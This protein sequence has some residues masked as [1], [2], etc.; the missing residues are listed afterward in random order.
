VAS[1]TTLVRL[2]DAK[3]YLQ[4]HLEAASSGLAPLTHYIRVG[5]A[6]GYDPHPM[7][8]TSWYLERYPDIAKAGMNPLVHYAQHGGFEGRDP[9]P[10][11]DTKWYLAQYPD[12]STT[13][14]NP[15][16]HYLEHGLAEGR[17]PGP[18]VLTP[19]DWE[20]DPSAAAAARA[21]YEREIG[22]R[23]PR[24]P[25]INIGRWPSPALLRWAT[26]CYR[27]SGFYLTSLLC[28]LGL[29]V[30]PPQLEYHLALLIKSYVRQG[31][32]DDA[33]RWFLHR[34]G[35]RPSGGP[36][37]L[38]AMPTISQGR[39]TYESIA[40][41]T[42]LM[43][44]RIAAQSA[45]LQSW[46]AAGMSVVSVNS[47][48][49]AIELRQYFPDVSYKTIEPTLEDMRGRPFVPIRALIETAK[50]ASADI[51]GIVN[52]DIE[53]RGGRDF[54]DTVRREVSGALVFGNRIDLTEAAATTGTAFRN[55]YDFFFWDRENSD[56][57]KDNPMLLGLPWWDFW[58]PLHAHAQGLAIK[59]IVTSAMVHVVHPIGWDTQNFLKFGQKSAE[60][61][62]NLYGRW[63]NAAP[64]AER[65]FLH[66]L[67]ATSATIPLDRHPELAHHRVGALCDLVNC[68]IDTLSETVV[69]PDARRAAGTMY[70]V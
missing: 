56:L 66:R 17:Q 36:I 46:R 63:G 60:T 16:V 18:L 4:R 55:G 67:F 40:V 33:L 42:S 19:K 31:K 13:G 26:A 62:A 11:F 45:A 34:I 69:L 50:E 43:P 23:G 2:F 3:W 70:L 21:A 27:H 68:L 51:C 5:A 1:D 37:V 61:L 52:S 47:K 54:I 44:R 25:Q 7:F 57:F 9:H 30:S 49:E 39:K 38:A 22:N 12:V 15:L 41:I 20:M 59:R 8:C 29:L 64:P 58:L 10:L 65:V 35:L 53:F 48:S 14:L 32:F 28:R 24:G 6:A